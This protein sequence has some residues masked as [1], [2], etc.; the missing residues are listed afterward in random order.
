MVSM[1]QKTK[2]NLA[3]FYLIGVFL[4][5]ATAVILNRWFA[6]LPLVLLVTWLVSRWLP[7][8]ND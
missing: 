8:S 7:R 4:L 5:L 2:D 3:L 1:K 6:C